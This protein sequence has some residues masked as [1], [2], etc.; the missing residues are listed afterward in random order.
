MRHPSRLL[1]VF[2][3]L[4]AAVVPGSNGALA[5]GI[6]R[7]TTTKCPRETACDTTLGIALKPPHGWLLLPAAKFPPHTLAFGT[8]PGNGASYNLRLVIEP[9]ALTSIGN[10]AE[11]AQ[12]VATKVI[13]AERVGGTTQLRVRYAGTR[14]VLVR[15]LPSPSP[16]AD[17]FLAHHQDV[18]QII[19]PGS[20]LAPDQRRAL[21][22]LRFIPRSGNFL[23]SVGGS[24]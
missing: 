3:L 21:A 14:G 24:R 17:I 5:G 4:A 11:A 20:A 8:L 23:P 16:A 15:G 13:R 12:W 18:Y 2:T 19:A 22:S 10:D 7:A 1:P 6:G 9:Y